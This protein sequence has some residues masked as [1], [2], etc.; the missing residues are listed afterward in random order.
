LTLFLPILQEFLDASIV[1]YRVA[2]LTRNVKPR[3][4]RVI[5]ALLRH[6]LSALN[7]LGA[8]QFIYLETPTM[9][10]ARVR[11]SSA[12]FKEIPNNASELEKMEYRG[13]LIGDLIYDA[14]LNRSG[15]HTVILSDEFL[16]VVF[17]EALIIV[18]FWLASIQSGKVKAIV[19]NH[20]VYLN[21]LAARVAVTNNVQVYQVDSEYLIKITSEELSPQREFKHFRNEFG[22]LTEEEKKLALIDAKDSLEK[23]FAG[24]NGIELSY[25]SNSPFAH[26][27]KEIHVHKNG[28]LNV[29]VSPHDFYDS[30][31]AFGNAF[32]PD[33]YIWLK[34]LGE[35]SNLTDYNWYIKTHPS[36]RGNGEI[37][38]SKLLESGLN[39]KLLPKLTSH[40][41]LV[42]QGMNVAL[43]V[44]GTIAMEYA[45]L[46][47][48]V[49]SASSDHPF[50]S[51]K[52]SI[53]PASV[54]EYEYMILNLDQFRA[55]SKPEEIYEC[56]Y[57]HYLHYPK[58]WFYR[59]YGKYLS[60]IGGYGYIDSIIDIRYF[61]SNHNQYSSDEIKCAIL[62]YLHSSKIRFNSRQFIDSKTQ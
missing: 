46:R 29:L 22:K 16:K 44:Y 36:L 24:D 25:L 59:D 33:F 56:Y 53:T 18:D 37:V 54:Q 23:R 61:L 38:I 48:T 51:Y 27:S 35:L 30:P 1:A 26:R 60:E 43:T 5:A 13:I 10:H 7:F 57:M 15:N 34:R 42:E 41:D 8:K 40:L 2:N 9:D 4:Y 31:H 3:R 39:W 12:F 6:K 58:N 55:A 52:F 21:G 28:K 45:A 32:Y 20:A 19:V 50:A 14:Y 11:E 47:A 62:E 17:Y 49:I